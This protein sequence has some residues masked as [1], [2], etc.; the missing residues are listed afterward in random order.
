LADLF[1]LV[2]FPAAG[3]NTVQASC[4]HCSNLLSDVASLQEQEVLLLGA[5]PCYREFLHHGQQRLSWANHAPD[6]FGRDRDSKVACY[7][8]LF[9]I[10]TNDLHRGGSCCCGSSS[11]LHLLSPCFSSVIY[12]MLKEEDK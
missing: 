10:S 4:N 8:N 5:V 1:Q 3:P 2:E 9:L 11:P 12:V 7:G 6:F